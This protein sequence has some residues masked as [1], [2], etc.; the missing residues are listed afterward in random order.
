[1]KINCFKVMLVEIP[2]RFSVEHSLAKRATAKNVLLAAYSEGQKVGWGESCPREY[3]TGETLDSVVNTLENTLCPYFEGREFS[4]FAQLVTALSEKGSRMERNQL[5]AFCALEMAL[6]DVAGKFF[7][8]SAGT[9]LGPIIHERVHYS[10]VIAFEDPQ[11]VAEAAKM[12]QQAHFQE[13]KVKLGKDLDNNRNILRIA[14]DIL[15]E[16][17]SLRGDANCAWDGQES[18]SQLEALA[19]FN[20]QGI[21]QPVPSEDTRGLKMIT[22]ARITPVAVDESLC[23]VTDA[24]ML[25]AEKACNIFN[26]RISKCGGL[27]NAQRIYQL[28]EKNG[29]RCQ[30]GAQVGETGLLSAAGRHLACRCPDLIWLEGSYGRLLLE[31]EL[32]EPDLTIGPQGIG[33][34]LDTDGIGVEPIAEMLEKYL[35]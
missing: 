6:L 19:E 28:A 9:V 16:D 30:L 33:M 17:V 29:L 34:A 2:M 21:E 24:E 22:A 32:C 10:A 26:I 25:I 35:V 4:S 18:I 3:V 31:E 12:I 1:M 8:E 11:A 14:R 27:L 15:G 20:L 23:S 13:I 7:H 5:A